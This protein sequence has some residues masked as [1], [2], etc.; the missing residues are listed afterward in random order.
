MKWHIVVAVGMLPLVSAK[1]VA[2]PAELEDKAR[3]FLAAVAR[4][5]VGTAVK[6]Y[7]DAMT[8][9]LPEEK[10][11]GLWKDLLRGAG[12]FKKLGAAKTA[13]VREYDIVTIRCD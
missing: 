4:D 8:K 2:Q 10:L 11:R 1:S 6:A 3:A 5:D 13:K 9:A 7:D 12:A